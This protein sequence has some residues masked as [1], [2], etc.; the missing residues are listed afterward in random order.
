[1]SQN[2]Y[3]FEYKLDDNDN[4]NTNIEYKRESWKEYIKKI[5]KRPFCFTKS[6]HFKK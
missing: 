4:D 3:I 5:I 2:D 1:M 6:N